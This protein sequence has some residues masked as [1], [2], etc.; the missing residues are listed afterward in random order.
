[1]VKAIPP[2][3]L[4]MGKS[5]GCDKLLGWVVSVLATLLEVKALMTRYNRI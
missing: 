1:M 5:H 4:V 3:F 2:K